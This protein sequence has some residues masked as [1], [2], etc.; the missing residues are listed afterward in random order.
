MLP[1]D[2]A[3]LLPYGLRSFFVRVQER[4]ERGRGLGPHAGPVDPGRLGPQPVPEA[5]VGEVQHG[6]GKLGQ[7]QLYE[8]HVLAHPGDVHER[9]VSN[10]R[11]SLEVRY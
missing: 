1:E 6:I 10:G 8:G 9:Q 11:Q 4:F 7:R 2:V 3:H 5:G